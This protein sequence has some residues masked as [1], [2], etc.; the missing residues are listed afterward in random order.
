M[1]IGI[2]FS[3]NKINIAKYSQG[4]IGN[5]REEYLPADSIEDL[6]LILTQRL[7][8]VKLDSIAINIPSD[9]GLMQKSRLY[10]FLQN[11]T[12]NISIIPTPL[13]AFISYLK[14]GLDISGD[15]LW[16]KKIHNQAYYE[17]A[18]V[19]YLPSAKDIILESFFIGS[20]EELT[21]EASRLNIYH[22]KKWK[23]Q[24]IFFIS[25]GKPE[26][27]PLFNELAVSGIPMVELKEPSPSYPSA[28]LTGLC[29]WNEIRKD[30]ALNLKIVYPRKFYRQVT[31]TLNGL[32]EWHKIYFDTENIELDLF[33]RYKIFSFPQ[34]DSNILDTGCQLQIGES[35]SDKDVLPSAE[36][37]MDIIPIINENYANQF[38]KST[39]ELY[40]DI[41]SGRFE[42]QPNRLPESLCQKNSAELWSEICQHYAKQ[43]AFLDMIPNVSNQLKNEY[44]R[45]LDDINWENVVA[46]TTLIDYMEK[47]LTIVKQL[48]EN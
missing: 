42:L 7:T 45:I 27:T 6:T 40:W 44:G 21:D 5:I 32:N 10:S 30:M 29:S 4:I 39:L 38:P 41:N 46:E 47:K 11:Y 36:C 34:E 17:L 33:G 19:N 12:S 25:S 1:H 26:P 9:W 18:F 31:N 23:L 14:Q 15:S 28:V 20:E 3:Q 24:Y 48:L 43:K 35:D 8:P 16:I 13:A 37:S 2:E 22:N